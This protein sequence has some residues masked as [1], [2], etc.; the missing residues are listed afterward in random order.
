MTEM[1]AFA[2]SPDG[3][4]VK[5]GSR[6]LAGRQGPSEGVSS[7]GDRATAP[8]EGIWCEKIRGCSCRDDNANSI[9]SLRL[10]LFDNFVRHQQHSLR[11]DRV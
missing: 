9:V 11:N 4:W 6:G 7:C 3:V 5:N 1:K 10:Q 8:I 2:A